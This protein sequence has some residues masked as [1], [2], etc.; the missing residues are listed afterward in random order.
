[1]PGL[2]GGLQGKKVLIP[3]G[4]GFIGS[5]LARECLSL[6]AAVTLYDCLDPRSG[7]NLRNIQE[8]RADVNLIHGDIREVEGLRKAVAGQ[9]VIFNCAAYTSHPNSMKEPY[10]D[11]E[12]NCKGVINQLEALRWVNPD[13]KFVQVGTSTQVGPMLRR[14]V[15]E[16]HPEFP[17]DI[18]SAN[19][20]VAEKYVLIYGS[21]YGLRTTVIR[22]SNTFGPRSNI[23]SPD[24]GFM[25]FFVGLALQGKEL[26]VYGDG[27]QLRTVGYVDDAV[28]SLI[29]AA[30]SEASNGKVFFS[31]ADKQY[32][33][34][35]LAREIARVMGGAVRFVE[36]PPE[37]RVLEVGDVVL[38][39][40][41]IRNALGW[42]PR[43]DLDA[44]LQKTR[45]YF[46]PLLEAYL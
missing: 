37:R 16:L 32:S 3:G 1:M 38:D 28:D 35:D 33:V 25:N 14:P 13:A 15:D 44:G 46:L 12:V 11:I 4:L 24:F 45:D 20:S 34:A 2:K 31:A 18:Y 42:V 8:I 30:Q 29:R 19:K 36:W 9:D 21:A 23:R 43:Y 22:L 7:G 17:T 39:A 27:A 6:G 10:I 40:T 5:N 41:A 26:P